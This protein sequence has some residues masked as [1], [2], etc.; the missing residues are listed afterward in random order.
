MI[1]IAINFKSKQIG[2]LVGY[3]LNVY[4]KM[5]EKNKTNRIVHKSGNS[6]NHILQLL[7]LSV[8]LSAFL[9]FY[10]DICISYRL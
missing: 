8:L 3:M 2:D 4:L 7:D 1:S 5:E 6:E 9:Y 10:F